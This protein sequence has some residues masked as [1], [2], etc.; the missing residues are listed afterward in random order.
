MDNPSLERYYYFFIERYR[1]FVEVL[2]Q[3]AETWINQTSGTSAGTGK[4]APGIAAKFWNNA[5]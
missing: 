4:S 2:G 5:V 1:R 3:R